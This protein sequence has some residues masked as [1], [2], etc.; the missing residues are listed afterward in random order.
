MQKIIPHL[1]FNTQAE[2][3]V[4]FY[5][6]LFRNSRI[7]NI[8]R[9]GEAGAKVSGKPTGAVMT[10]AFLLEG[11]PFMALNG[12]PQFTFSPA[13]SFL[14]NCEMQEEVDTLWRKLC[15]GGKPGQCGWLTD[16][17]GVSW[18]IIPTILGKLMSDPDPAKSERVMKAML[19]MSKLDIKKLQQAAE[20]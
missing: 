7:M 16:K 6:S 19:T 12:G 10:I 3:A 13:I 9:Y 14:V 11:Q 17:Y 15:E 18:Q 4:N 5:T 1:W 20:Q 8:S 2:E